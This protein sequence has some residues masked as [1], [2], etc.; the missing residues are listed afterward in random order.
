MD[1]DPEQASGRDGFVRA[2]SARSKRCIGAG[3]RS[4]T[5]SRCGRSPTL[6][7]RGRHAEDLRRGLDRT[8]IV[9]PHEGAPRD[10]A[11][12]DREAPHRRHARG[13]RPGQ[14]AAGAT[15]TG[16]QSAM[17]L[18][19][20][21]SVDLA[22]TLL[23]AQEIERLGTGCSDRGATRLL[24]RPHPPADLSQTR[25]ARRHRQEPHPPK[26]D[27]HANPIGGRRCRIVDPKQLSRILI[28]NSSRSWRWASPWPRTRMRRAH[29]G[30]PRLPARTR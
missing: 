24:R 14:A 6:G 25:H 18:V 5:P 21:P 12:H 22:E 2:T 11:H 1:A 9:R 29:R 17:T 19:A 15:R 3:R 30:M 27:P 26:S 23:V 10:L 7:C 20:A 28:P 16:D 13:P 4:S 8:R